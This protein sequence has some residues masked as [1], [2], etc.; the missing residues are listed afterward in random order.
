MAI[1]SATMSHNCGDTQRVVPIHTA[2]TDYRLPVLHD[3]S[4]NHTPPERKLQQ[5]NNSVH[6]VPH[7]SDLPVYHHQSLYRYNE[8][9]CPAHT[10]LC[11]IELLHHADSAVI[12][13]HTQAPAQCRDENRVVLS[14]HHS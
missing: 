9:A 7:E 11:P 14:H 12:A 13:R 4:G 2:K 5:A 6:T 8:Y 10:G 1:L 3:S